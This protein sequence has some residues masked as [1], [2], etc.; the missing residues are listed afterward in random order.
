[1]TSLGTLLGL[2][3]DQQAAFHS[4]AQANFEALTT[5]DRGTQVRQVRALAR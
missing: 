2:P 1:M 3:D 4:Q 5:S